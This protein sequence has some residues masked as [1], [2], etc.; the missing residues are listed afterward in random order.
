[1]SK[2]LH[3]EERRGPHSVG[4]HVRDA[5]AYVCWAFARAYKPAAMADCLHVLT[6]SLLM[7]SC[8]D[9]EVN[10]RRA[11]S[12][13]FQESVGRL[14]AENFPNGIEILTSADYYS[15][16][17]RK[18]AYLTVG[19]TIASL[20]QYLVPLA[21]H[22]L[23]NKLKNWD[24]AVRALAADAL[25]ELVH[26][27]P[28]YFADVALPLMLERSV[29]MGSLETRHGALLATAA[30]VQALADVQDVRRAGWGVG[31]VR[32]ALDVQKR[33]LWR[34]KGGDLMREALCKLIATLGRL[35]V[36]LH[37]TQ[38]RRTPPYASGY[39]QLRRQCWHL[40]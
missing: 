2:A 28:Q 25:A 9:R 22:L 14:G 27:Q 39:V 5:A 8:Y 38:V 10:C 4:G 6:P 20:P 17:S 40:L 3:Y 31:A 33:Q 35:R 34:G 30:L 12:A 1:M 26:L 29:D 11:A 32:V 15:L 23:E 21:E 13:A 7:A 19:P 24:A 16:G 37:G 36:P 18:Q